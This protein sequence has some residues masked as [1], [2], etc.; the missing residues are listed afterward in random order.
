MANMTDHGKGMNPIWAAQ[1][2]FRRRKFDEAIEICT[3][4]LE[5]NPYDQAS[6]QCAVT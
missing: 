1:S 6:A 3:T 2:R 5:K 4:L